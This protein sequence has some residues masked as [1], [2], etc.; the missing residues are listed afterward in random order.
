MLILDQSAVA[1]QTNEVFHR[2]MSGADAPIYVLGRNKYAQRVSRAVM[3]E[4]FVDDFTKDKS[5][6]GKPV[7]RMTDLPGKCIVVSCV[8]DT[9][10]V[11]A[12]DRLRSAGRKDAIDYFTLSR[13]APDL[14]G[15]VDF[16][17]GNRQ[18][19]L[20][21][22]AQYEWVFNRLADET[23]RRSFARLVQ[24]RLTMDVE[25]M[26]GFSLAIDRQ[27]F[28]DFLPPE[29]GEVFVDGGGFDGQTTAQFAARNQA[30]QRIHYFEPSP[31]M[32]EVSRGNLAGLRDVNFVQK[33]LF[34][35]NDR[36]R[37][38]AG[39]GSASSLSP[40]GQIEIEVVRLDD[41][42]REPITFLKLDIEGAEYEAIQ[43]AA[44]HIRS[45]TPTLAVCIYH[46]QQDFWRVPQRVLEINDRYNLFVRHYSESVRET[47]MFFVPVSSRARRPL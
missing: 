10:P 41:E 39:A 42:V 40:T 45:E 27:Y 33:G 1:P 16:C 6:L 36:L 44:E 47:V 8:T 7:I 32:M 19:I 34:S 5:Y 38:E 28:E 26:R 17:A 13:L 30:Y 2:L 18:D 14:F 24:F 15:P 4:A 35:R 37:F 31:A 25:Y 11:T 20:E 29:A 12:L 21:N 22:T 46:N 3:V 23:S 43:G 9:L